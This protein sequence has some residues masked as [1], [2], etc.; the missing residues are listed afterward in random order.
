MGKTLNA[1][2]PETG[3]TFSFDWNRAGREPDAIDLESIYKA[4]KGMQWEGSAHTQE[5]PLLAKVQKFAA[6]VSDQAIGG[7]LDTARNAVSRAGEYYAGAGGLPGV[8]GIPGIAQRPEMMDLAVNK[9]DEQLEPPGQMLADA[10]VPQGTFEGKGAGNVGKGLVHGAARVVGGFADPENLA[11]APLLG[12]LPARVLQIGMAL[13]AAGQTK[14]A[15][16]LLQAQGLTGET[17]DKAMQALGTAAMAWIVGPKKI[18]AQGEIVPESMR[19]LPPP[20]GKPAGWNDVVEG[21]VVKTPPALN[22]KPPIITPPPM[23]APVT[24]AP[25]APERSLEDLISVVPQAEGKRI[26][27]PWAKGNEYTNDVMTVLAN[28]AKGGFKA[29]IQMEPAADGNEWL[30]FHREGE[31][32]PEAAAK[33]SFDENGNAKVIDFVGKSKSEGTRALQN[34]IYPNVPKTEGS[35]TVAGEKARSNWEKSTYAPDAE[36]AA[37]MPDQFAPAPGRGPLKGKPVEATPGGLP[38]PPAAETAKPKTAEERAARRIAARLKK[39]GKNANDVL[40]IMLRDFPALA[41]DATVIAAIKGARGAKDLGEFT[42][43]VRGVLKDRIDSAGFMMA[44]DASAASR[45]PEDFWRKAY[46][47]VRALDYDTSVPTGDFEKDSTPG[48]VYSS[49]LRDSVNA[50]KD[51]GPLHG[52]STSNFLRKQPGVTQDEMV[53][54]GVDSFLEGTPKTSKGELLGKVEEGTPKLADTRYSS[55]YK[56]LTLDNENNLAQHYQD[57]E[58]RH[59]AASQQFN[60]TLDNIFGERTMQRPNVVDPDAVRGPVPN[61][62][63]V[64]DIVRG[65]A[66]DRVRVTEANFRQDASAWGLDLTHV[67]NEEMAALVAQANDF[68]RAENELN[69][70]DHAMANIEDRSPA[71]RTRWDTLKLPG[72]E[73]YQENLQKLPVKTTENDR[74]AQ[75]QQPLISPEDNFMHPHWAG[76][77]NVLLHERFDTRIDSEGKS[78]VMLHEMQSDLHQQGQKK[79]YNTKAFQ[80]AQKEF[81]RLATLQNKLAAATENTRAKFGAG[82]EKPWKGAEEVFDKLTAKSKD[83]TAKLDA[84]IKEHG[85]GVSDSHHRLPSGQRVPDA[86]FKKDEQWTSLGL[87]R[88]VREAAEQ[89]HDRVYWPSTP[90]QV[91]KI[92]GWGS[93]QTIQP[94][95]LANITRPT[96][97]IHGRDVTPI[98]NRYLELLPRLARDLGK[99]FG[100]TVGKTRIDTDHVFGKAGTGAEGG[101]AVAGREVFYLDIPDSLRT[102]ALTKGLPLYGQPMNVPQKKALPGKDS[103]RGMMVADL[104][105]GLAEGANTLGKKLG[106]VYRA[107]LAGGIRTAESNAIQGLGR[108]GITALTDAVAAVAALPFSTRMAKSFGSR[109]ANRIRLMTDFPTIMQDVINSAMEAGTGKKPNT[110]RA[111]VAKEMEGLTKTFL[112]G[113]LDER[114]WHYFGG[115]INVPGGGTKP[116]SGLDKVTR[117]MVAPNIIQDR[118]IRLMVLAHE[119]MPIMKETRSATYTDLARKAMADPALNEKLT[120]ALHSGM[121]EALSVTAGLPPMSGALKDFTAAVHKF[122][123]SWLVDPF[124]DYALH[125]APQQ[126]LESAPILNLLSKRIRESL[127]HPELK[128]DLKNAMTQMQALET[129]HTVL[130]NRVNNARGMGRAALKAQLVALE[131]QMHQHNEEKVLPLKGKAT[132]AKHEGRYTLEQ[133]IEH[134]M[135][136]APMM[137]LFYAIRVSK[138][139]DNTDFHQKKDKESGKLSSGLAA[140][141]PYAPWALLGDMVA[142]EQMKSKYYESRHT[143]PFM[144]EF[145]VGLGQSRFPDAPSARSLLDSF[146]ADDTTKDDT[147]MELANKWAASVGRAFGKLGL[148][149][150]IAR[151]TLSNDVGDKVQGNPGVLLPGDKPLRSAGARGFMN[152]QPEAIRHG[153]QVPP[154]YDSSTGEK[155]LKDSQMTP[156][157]SSVKMDSKV[158]EFLRAHQSEISPKDVY[159]KATGIDWYDK[160]ATDYLKIAI[161]NRVEPLIN[162][163]S[164]DEAT[165]V[166]A[167]KT[168]MARVR[169]TAHVVARKEGASNDLPLPPRIARMAADAEEREEMRKAHPEIFKGKRKPAGEKLLKPEKR[170]LQDKGKKQMEEPPSAP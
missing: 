21:Q 121:T 66:I 23:E 88:M 58:L 30:Y 168:V 82:K 13:V 129:Q 91:A 45:I 81:D 6:P 104:A 166:E 170:A 43:R 78:G 7:Y 26:E 4:W 1:T 139:E 22:E 135:I 116:V 61:S 132:T 14:E 142:R 96:Y 72:G 52:P 36:R 122:G 63:V 101:G 109:A 25:V 143:W 107:S 113:E 111:N 41:K 114:M 133:M 119:L 161:K 154:K 90:E 86:P 76:E 79:G 73:K 117:T 59:G 24:A 147:R 77:P 106:K 57:A 99:K 40:M 20:P 85:M 64:H 134:A 31:W 38:P 3:E 47:G 19:Q 167:V 68:I 148:Y 56:P 159:F 131:Q 128:A 27:V 137:A 149:G 130:R 18:K 160:A 153:F 157:P 124:F 115:V 50:M 51:K 94:G 103:E 100:A 164:L 34:L 87:K 55:E 49:N 8:G 125:Q 151:G 120:D 15:Y 5:T 118:T 105:I 146:M 98:V 2:N 54:S 42:A 93:I 70:A 67:T 162:D 74:L 112:P 108:F 10:A 69:A 152:E 33:L 37:P 126:F 169:D 53:E 156:F 102:L 136:F 92:E 165:K 83:I 48:P 28:D 44:Q 150:D 95:E 145:L 12:M 17:A 127:N 35:L 123:W 144:R 62:Q 9:P 110:Q 80:D 84:L 75:G 163:A 138:G 16:D 39:M 29:G 71:N 158:S 60:E 32:V 155:E 11:M 97:L 89:G 65:R 141:G 140:L 46:A